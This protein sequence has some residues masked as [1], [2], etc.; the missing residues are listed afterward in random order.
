[1]FTPSNEQKDSQKNSSGP[2]DDSS[3]NLLRRIND[4]IEMSRKKFD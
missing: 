1:M 3:L 4:D 2:K